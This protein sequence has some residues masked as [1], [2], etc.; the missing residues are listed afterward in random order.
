MVASPVAST[1]PKVV[2]GGVA[3]GFHQRWLPKIA[4]NFVPGFAP[5]S[6]KKDS[7]FCVLRERQSFGI[8]FN[9]A[10]K[11]KINKISIKT[12]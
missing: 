10:K 2:G 5:K 9:Q 11:C 1:P 4:K 8:H 3:C 6:L 12:R 7:V